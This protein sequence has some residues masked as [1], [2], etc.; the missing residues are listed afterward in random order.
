[1]PGRSRA[2]TMLACLARGNLL[3]VLHESCNEVTA[4]FPSGKVPFASILYPGDPGIRRAR[5][6]QRRV[7]P[8]PG[9]TQRALP[10]APLLATASSFPRPEPR[11][12]EQ[13]GAEVASIFLG[14][15]SPGN[16][17]G[18]SSRD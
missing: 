6:P 2:G 11:T 8:G 15:S 17:Q 1:M 9:S 7:Q 10:T 14:T 13:R 18:W 16:P 4:H 12:Q 5:S 3:D